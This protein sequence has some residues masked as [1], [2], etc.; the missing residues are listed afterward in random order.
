MIRGIEKKGREMKIVI[1]SFAMSSLARR[2]LI[3]SVGW[4]CWLF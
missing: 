3:V 2:R 1:G 4:S